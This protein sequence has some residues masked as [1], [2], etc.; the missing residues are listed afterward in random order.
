MERKKI[1]EIREKL[2]EEL[3]KV[4]EGYCV[5]L[6]NINYY[7]QDL[8][9]D[10]NENRTYKDI[11]SREE[12]HPRSFA[13]DLKYLKKIDFSSFPEDYFDDF[14][15]SGFDFSVLNNVT[16]SN[17]NNIYAKDYSNTIL[18]GVTFQ[19]PFNEREYI[20]GADF[21]GSKGVKIEPGRLSKGDETFK[22][23]SLYL[24]SFNNCNFKDA[25]FLSDI[26][27]SA[28]F[29][30]ILNGTNF[31][32]SHNAIIHLNDVISYDKCNFSDT[33]LFQTRPIH[34]DLNSVTFKNTKA[35]KSKTERLID[36]ESRV[37][38]D[39]KDCV[40]ENC[41]FNGVAFIDDLAS[42]KF[43]NCD[44]TDSIILKHYHQ[45]RYPKEE[46][47]RFL[48]MNVN[49]RTKEDIKK[50]RKKLKEELDKV[51]EGTYVTLNGVVEDRLLMDNK[52]E[53]IDGEENVSFH[54]AIEPEYLKKIDFSWVDKS[55]FYNF[56]ARGFDFGILHNVYLYSSHGDGT[57]QYNNDFS[58][59]KLK[60][61]HF[62]TN[63]WETNIEGTDFSESKGVRINPTATFEKEGEYNGE[64][65]Y[66]HVFKNC[67]FQN[68]VFDKISSYPPDFML[69]N[70]YNQELRTRLPIYYVLDGASFAGSRY[71]VIHTNGV[72]SYNNCN[73]KDA[74]IYQ[75]QPIHRDLIGVKFKGALA[76]RSKFDRR[77]NRTSKILIDPEGCTFTDCDFDGVAFVDKLETGKFINC[78]LENVEVLKH[79]K[80]E[81]PKKQFVFYTLDSK[82]V[83]T[84]SIAENYIEKGNNSVP[85]TNEFVQEEGFIDKQILIE[86]EEIENS[87]KKREELINQKIKDNLDRIKENNELIE[88]AKTEN[89]E[90]YGK[91]TIPEDQFL[92]QEGDHLAI[93]PII[94]EKGILRCFNLSAIDFTN[95]R[96]GG[97]K[98][99]L[100]YRNTGARI[101]PQKV[102]DKDL[103]NCILDR[104]NVYFYDRLEG[105]NLD[106][107]NLDDCDIVFKEQ[108]KGKSII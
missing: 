17:T 56:D 23:R 83:D 79:Y 45:E 67:N 46:N 34:R 24:T 37:L 106:G 63:F 80:G 35:Y 3:D 97:Y 6:K 27:G 26:I 11:F 8:L 55:F 84:S 42:G 68:V 102:Y 107:T 48:N 52:Q 108:N 20:V 101:N 2:K 22:G 5:Q 82:E 58:N 30:Y 62:N 13:L 89:K 61:V 19:D 51:P 38:I 99:P 44:L 69:C 104:G 25:A 39:P 95:V 78:N 74:I 66:L 75:E 12:A 88:Q 43:I 77:I 86:A 49:L 65:V 53:F 64:Q 7:N 60:G 70:R 98:V 33:I 1:L 59:A 85:S 47:Y 54:F 10:I 92:V 4:P 36:I 90:I 57:A 31:E 40:F 29:K 18:R 76:I 21:S 87:K 28:H 73:F 14:E 105:V 15:A 81:R 50:A 96:V 94:I 32:G 9:F 91:I 100:D 41:V 71:A 93:N 103:S 72:L 16:I